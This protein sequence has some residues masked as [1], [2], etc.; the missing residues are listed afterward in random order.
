MMIFLFAFVSQFLQ[1]LE[2]NCS[3]YIE[4]KFIIFVLKTLP[5]HQGYDAGHTSGHLRHQITSMG[6]QRCRHM[7]TPERAQPED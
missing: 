5:A 6:D 3:I 7:Y 4:L 2:K 1:E